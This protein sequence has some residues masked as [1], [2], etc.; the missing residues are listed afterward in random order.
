MHISTPRDAELF[1]ARAGIA[2]RYHGKGVALASVRAATGPEDSKTAL[3]TSITLTNHLLGT[4]LAIEVNVIADRVVLVH[5]SIM[6]ALYA[7]VRRGRAL[8]DL[9]GLSLHARTALAVIRDRREA[10]VGDVRAALGVKTGVRQ[11]PAYDALGELGQRLLVDR[12]PFEMPKSGIPYLSKDGY[13]YHLFH[14]AHADLV[15]AAAAY[16]R[17]DAADAFLVRYL[18]GGQS[19]TRRTLASLFKRFLTRDEIA[20]S[21]DRLVAED[22]VAL[23]PRGRDTLVAPTRDT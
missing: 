7:L 5:R 1:L 16:S 9:E 20:Q 14:Q 18:D 6:P 4:A 23:R 11:D 2:L 10:S 3:V 17:D 13:P 22:R 15:K 21:I 8:T 12:G 19:V